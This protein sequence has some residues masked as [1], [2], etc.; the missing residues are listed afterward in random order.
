MNREAIEAECKDWIDYGVEYRWSEKL[1]AFLRSV[2]ALLRSPAVDRGPVD[3]SR[4]TYA[5]AEPQGE[6]R[7]KVRVIFQE[8][9]GR[10]YDFDDEIDRVFRLFPSPDLSDE[11]L[12]LMPTSHRMVTIP[13]SAEAGKLRRW[14]DRTMWDD[15]TADNQEDFRRACNTSDRT[16]FDC[17]S[18]IIWDHQRDAALRGTGEK[19]DDKELRRGENVI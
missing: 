15:L 10:D 19:G 18:E 5:P 11:T 17:V 6:L 14:V 3:T 9:C 13:A 4:D 1:I 12:P 2:Q 8:L 16:A 7:G